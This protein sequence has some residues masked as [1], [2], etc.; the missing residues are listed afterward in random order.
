MSK[1]QM[2]FKKALT[3]CLPQLLEEILSYNESQKVYGVSFITTDDFY[4][5]YAAFVTKEFMDEQVKSE[6][7]KE[8]KRWLPT[9]WPFSDSVQY[10]II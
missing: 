2:F 4:G 9:E 8:Y 10:L 3:A 6:S 5:M 7:E 1:E